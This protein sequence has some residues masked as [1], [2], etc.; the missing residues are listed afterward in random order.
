MTEGMTTDPT[1]VMDYDSSE[2][3]GDSQAH[4]CELPISH[5]IMES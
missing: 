1:S 3:K 4:L 5:P 2:E